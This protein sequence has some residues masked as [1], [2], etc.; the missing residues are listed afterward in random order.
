MKVKKLVVKNIGM[1]ADAEIKFDHALMLFYG[2]IKQGKTTL[3]NSVRWVCGGSFPSDIIRHG[4]KSAYIE[5]TLWTSPRKT[6]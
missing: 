3:L 2:E 6:N 5:L 4:E 1:V